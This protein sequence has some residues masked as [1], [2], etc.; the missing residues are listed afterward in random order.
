ML[1]LTTTA[2]RVMG[3]IGEYPLCGGQENIFNPQG[4]VI[5]FEQMNSAPHPLAGESARHENLKTSNAGQAITTGTELVN[6]E[7]LLIVEFDRPNPM[8]FV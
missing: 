4:A 5:S 6:A 3:T 2:F 7:F 1:Q 8:I